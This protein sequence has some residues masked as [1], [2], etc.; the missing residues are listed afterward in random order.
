MLQAILRVQHY[1]MLARE[2][3]KPLWSCCSRRAP[4]KTFKMNLDSLH[5]M[6]QALMADIPS[7]RFFS[8][9][10]QTQISGT[11]DQK[12]STALHAASGPAAPPTCANGF[13]AIVELLLKKSAD[14]N[15]RDA[16]GYTPLDL[17]KLPG[18]KKNMAQIIK[19]LEGATLKAWLQTGSTSVVAAFVESAAGLDGGPPLPILDWP[20]PEV[21]RSMPSAVAAEVFE[22][23]A[24]YTAGVR[25]MPIFLRKRGTA[26]IRARRTILS[27]LVFPRTVVRAGAK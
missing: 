2:V 26:N 5:F 17:T 6:L 4:T 25:S 20:L 24:R 23:V 14:I 13:P 15:A 9:M 11:R 12:E 10:A 27:F 8:R 16:A 19:L 1:I 7:C 21:V 22:W 18:N 3:D